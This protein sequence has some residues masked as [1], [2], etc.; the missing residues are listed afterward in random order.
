MGYPFVHATFSCVSA[1]VG[2]ITVFQTHVLAVNGEMHTN[3]DPFHWRAWPVAQPEPEMETVP[4]AIFS[5]A[6]AV[7]TVFLF[8]WQV[9]VVPFH[10]K[11]WP[12]AVQEMSETVEPLTAMP[13]P[14]VGAVLSS[15]WQVHVVPFHFR[16]WPFVVQEVS[17]IV[18]FV[19]LTLIPA[20][21][22]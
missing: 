2:P 17:E 12:F 8:A 15:A 4:F 11:I 5:G 6:A 7:I 19:L 21:D 3:A 1:V 13:L 14:A 10:F 22:V 18:V 16:I 9:H 20:P